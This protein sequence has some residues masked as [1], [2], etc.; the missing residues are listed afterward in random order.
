MIDI[1][2]AID[3]IG[4]KC[5]RLTQGDYAQKKIYND[6][7]LE[8]A[9]RFEDMGVRRLHLV[10]L[11]GAK[12]KRV[13][14]YPVLEQITAKTKLT[15]DFGGGIKSD[16]DLKKVFGSGA[17]MA[18]IGSVAVT[19]REL[20]LQW[21][22]TWG[23][24]RIILGADSKDRKI[25]ISGWLD[26][27]AIDLFDFMEDYQTQGISKYLCTDISRDGM[28]QGTALELY[29]E[30]RAHFPKAYLIASGGVSS[31]DEIHQLEEMGVDA[32]I[33]GK[34][35]YEGFITEKHIR[36]IMLRG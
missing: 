35:Y 2:P 7:P 21:L 5:V 11:E 4:G 3:L 12:E 16:D 25:A 19:Q 24:E 26:T 34:A 33:I 14:N 23:T 6:N 22:Q 9:Q 32:A 18:T 17:A 30:M 8:V 1:I 36:E 20:F 27:T 31:V 10:D 13:V 28:M 15:I 29:R